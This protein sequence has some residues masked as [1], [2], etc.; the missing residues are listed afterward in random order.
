M[1]RLDVLLLYEP[2]GAE[3]ISHRPE[4]VSKRCR[5]PKTRN[6]DIEDDGDRRLSITTLKKHT[7]LRARIRKEETVTEI[8]NGWVIADFRDLHQLAASTAPEQLLGSLAPAMPPILVC[9]L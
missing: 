1:N 3:P 2:S 5:S 6:H 9:Y 8:Y 4:D 7:S